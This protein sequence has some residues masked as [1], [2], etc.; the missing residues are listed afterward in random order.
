MSALDTVTQGT[1]LQ[2]TPN[3]FYGLGKGVVVCILYKLRDL[4]GTVF[5]LLALE[6]GRQQA[7]YGSSSLTPG[8]EQALS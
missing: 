6:E 4:L 8:T 2:G 3:L 7:G 1:I 5:Q